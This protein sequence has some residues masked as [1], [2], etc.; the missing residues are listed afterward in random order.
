M[1][2][3]LVDDQSLITREKQI[4]DAAVVLIQQ[5]GIENLTMDKVVA[6]VPFSKG[7]VYKHFLGKEDLLLSVSNQAISILSDL[8]WRASLY[9]GCARER[10]QLLN[11]S[12][13][14]Y[15]I[16]HPALFKAVICAKSPNVYGKSSEQRLQQQE[17][18]ETKL[19]GAMF[20]IIE[21]G[22]AS[23]AFTL[24][25]HMDM[26]Q[27]CFA[28]WSMGYGTIALLSSEVDECGGRNGLVV[29]R[30]LFNQNNLL[31]DGLQWAPLAHERDYGA[32]L[33]VAL[34]QVFPGELALMKSMGR[35]LNF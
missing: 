28:N 20:G 19:M 9:D 15:A 8:F 33:R 7:T 3:R 1:S 21:E 4:I 23:N 29:E 2:P 30:E 25:P 14:I 17:Q 12:Y 18:H 10:M 13:L 32:A 35:E 5:L 26:Q 31:Y 16:L 34:Q 11:M 22:I 27:V 24:P 6:K